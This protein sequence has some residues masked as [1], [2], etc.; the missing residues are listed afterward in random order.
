MRAAN[1]ER[2]IEEEMVDTSGNEVY[3]Y[4]ITKGDALH[5]TRPSYNCSYCRLE[6]D[7]A[8]AIST[9]A[10][11]CG[12]MLARKYRLRTSQERYLFD[13]HHAARGSRA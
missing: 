12:Q 1:A 7:M 4:T 6:T 10:L 3:N 8:F 9:V 2:E 13:P 11:L 5:Q